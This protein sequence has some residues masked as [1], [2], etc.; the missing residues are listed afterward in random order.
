VVL[1]IG[2]GTKG[3]ST[4]PFSTEEGWLAGLLRLLREAP[5]LLVSLNLRQGSRVRALPHPIRLLARG[6]DSSRSGTLRL[7]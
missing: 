7:A 1:V 3:T 2:V 6:L 4:V 5:P